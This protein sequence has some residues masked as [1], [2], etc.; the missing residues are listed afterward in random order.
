MDEPTSIRMGSHII[1][2]IFCLN[3]LEKREFLKST[4]WR[5]IQ[6]NEA[7]HV[8]DQEIPKSNHFLFLESS[9]IIDGGIEEVVIHRIKVGWSK[10]WTS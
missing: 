1:Y 2:V 6:R 10:T 9:F 3:W 7:V 4:F 5:N 8:D